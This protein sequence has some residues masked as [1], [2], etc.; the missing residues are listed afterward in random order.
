MEGSRFLVF[1]H[2]LFLWGPTS[3]HDFNWPVNHNSGPQ[4][5]ACDPGLDSHLLPCDSDWPNN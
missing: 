5:Q 3:P 4:G 1:I 2:P